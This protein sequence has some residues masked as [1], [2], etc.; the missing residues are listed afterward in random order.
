[1]KRREFLEST[2]KSLLVAPLIFN[3][4]FSIL[5]G[6]TASHM[7]SVFDPLA[8]ALKMTPG[9]TPNRDGVIV[10]TILSYAVNRT[11]VS[12]M[13]DTAVMKLTGKPSVGL[14]WETLFPEGQLHR[15]TKI[16][17][18]LNLSYGER[19]EKNDWSKTLC[20]FGP[21]VALSDAIILGLSQMLD[22]TFPIENVT[23]FD[24]SYSSKLRKQ[25]SLIQ[26][27]RPVFPN[28][29]GKN[30][31]NTE[32]TYGIH[33]VIPRKRSEIPDDAPRF[34]AAPDFPKGYHAPQR[35]I[36]AV[37]QNDFMINV[38]N[39]KTHREA[40]VTGVM[41]NT[42]GCTDNPYGTHGTEW[43]Y[44]DSPYPGSRRCAP[45]FYKSLN[46]HT[47]CIL[48]VLDALQG[49][50]AGGPLS[51][52]VFQ[53]NT[54]SVSRDPVAIDTQV[55][56]LVNKHRKRDG[57]AILST[58]D[59]RTA[60]GFPNA[61]FLQIAEDTHKMGSSSMDHHKVYDLSGNK[62]KYDIPILEKSQ[63]R[64]SDVH[65]KRDK[66]R[67]DVWLD[68]SKRKHRIESRI[69]DMHG[70]ILKQHKTTTT[71]RSRLSLQWNHLDE[72]RKTLG[73]GLYVWQVMVDGI[74]HYR[75]INDLG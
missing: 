73:E 11:R 55:L 62:E 68:R 9:S 46:E 25:F 54:I 4:R 49:V 42:F 10:D 50:Y 43:Q 7:V 53:E 37:Y 16:S 32:G 56:N 40:G 1:M 12:N 57:L 13:L 69:E 70:N 36:P 66:Y 26:G 48:N 64:V 45:V 27:Y 19:E 51:G 2:A 52:K 63:S 24:M 18:K 41:K 65:R 15:D 60:D 59:G 35:I 17:I 47:P 6:S 29:E 61:T 31:D 8:T 44:P 22:G 71:K 5:A 75:V 30:K 23:I 28:E 33:W 74:R 39:A 20:P 34:V 72:N 3:R 58:E 21:K 14:A 67:V 38:A